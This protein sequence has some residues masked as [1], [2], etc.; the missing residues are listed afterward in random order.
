MKVDPEW[1]LYQA[2]H[3]F[4]TVKLLGAIADHAIASASGDDDEKVRTL[5]AAVSRYDD[6]LQQADTKYR[7][8]LARRDM[9]T[10][11]QGVYD[12][13]IAQIE[14]VTAAATAA[15]NFAA[16]A[17]TGRFPA[18]F[19]ESE[20]LRLRREVSAAD[21]AAEDAFRQ[22][23]RD[24][25]LEAL[26]LREQAEADRDPSARMA[27][28]LERS[29]LAASD[30]NPAI[31]LE[32]AEAALRADRPQRA[33]LLLSV[34]IDRGAKG[35]G[36]LMAAVEDAL[37]KADPT[38]KQ[39]RELEDTVAEHTTE[40]EAKRLDVLQV[41]A[42]GI[43]E[44]GSVGTGT[45]EDVARASVASKL[46]AYSSGVREFP[47]SQGATGELPAPGGAA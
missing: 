47:A 2:R 23:R 44:N 41:S 26:N 21:G 10:R 36:E 28:E 38:R 5:A 4:L 39:A 34:A 27:D 33:S 24:T 19:V 46:A 12:R 14:A 9:T 17:A 29:R 40:F 16:E 37:D 18:S 35:V 13:A 1:Q 43:A 22:Y 11:N 32:R 8:K 7:E 30:T 6:L 45:S 3:A 15:A 42:V 20:R 25:L 31:F